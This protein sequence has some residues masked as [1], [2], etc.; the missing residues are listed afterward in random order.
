M[1]GNLFIKRPKFAIVISLAIILAGLLCLTTLPL[2]EY[3]SITPPQVIVSAT[4]SGANADV[5]TSTIAAPIEL[6]LNG[7]ED[8]IYMSSESSNGTYNLTVYF[9]VGSDPDMNLVN[10]QNQLQLVTPRLPEEVR[11][12]GLTVRKSTGGGGCV[13]IGVSSPNGTYDALYLANY[14]SLYIKDELARTKGCARVQ[15]FGAG[16]YSMRIWL[17]P[18]KMAN[19]G[20]STSDI[21]NAITSQNVQTPAGNIGV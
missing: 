10:V 20:V 1:A 14:A 11:R 5:I 9:E 15:V 7:V 2:E 17:K 21:S 8:M 13:F 4:Y 19:L 18:D 3:P 16:D 12:Y 6:Q